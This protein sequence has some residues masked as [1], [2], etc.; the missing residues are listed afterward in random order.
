MTRLIKIA[1]PHILFIYFIK[2]EGHT[3]AT[4]VF[5]KPKP[6]QSQVYS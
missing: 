1:W 5:W 3:T 4:F 2:K 6:F